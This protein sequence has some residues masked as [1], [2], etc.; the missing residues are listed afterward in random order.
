ME[1]EDVLNV[2]PNEVLIEGANT[3]EKVNV[4]GKVLKF[5]LFGLASAAAVVLG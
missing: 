4:K 3:P 1:M 2:T 5:A